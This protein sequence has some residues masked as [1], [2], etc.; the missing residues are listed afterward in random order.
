MSVYHNTEVN[1]DLC[2]GHNLMASTSAIYLLRT[3]VQTTLFTYLVGIIITQA[4]KHAHVHTH[5]HTHTHLLNL[6][7]D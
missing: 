4:H 1:L 7:D 5:T 2:D 6:Q 3:D